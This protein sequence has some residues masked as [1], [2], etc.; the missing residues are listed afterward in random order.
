MT[1]LI[2]LAFVG[3]VYLVIYLTYKLCKWIDRDV[4]K[5]YYGLTEGKVKKGGRNSRPSTK[6]PDK[7][8]AASKPK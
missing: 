2:G 8:P 7:P 4:P 3:G 5:D 1:E 6:R